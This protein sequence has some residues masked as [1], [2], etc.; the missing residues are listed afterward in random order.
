[1]ILSNLIDAKTP[2]IE[3]PKIL[4]GRDFDITPNCVLLLA[5]RSYIHTKGTGNCGTG[6]NFPCYDK[7]TGPLKCGWY[8]PDIEVFTAKAWSLFSEIFT[9]EKKQNEFFV[10]FDAMNEISVAYKLFFE[11]VFEYNKE[12]PI[13]KGMIEDENIMSRWLK[14]WQT[15]Q[16]SKYERYTDILY[17]ETL[18]PAL[19]TLL[20]SKEIL[21][22]G[23]P[24]AYKEY[25]RQLK[26][27]WDAV[28]ENGVIK[29]EPKKIIK[30]DANRKH[31]DRYA[32]STNEKSEIYDAIGLAF[33]DG[34]F[35]EK[36]EPLRIFS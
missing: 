1:M 7:N 35:S 33:E 22:K 12:N 3:L 24:E 34:Y 36:C 4:R 11:G 25:M 32:H 6:A 10:L 5:E 8:E 23:F 28:I 13:Y 21:C 31:L 9:R 14:W 29:A 19:Q 18:S 16:G 17:G 26:R 30:T 20:E 27:V 15:P 2:S